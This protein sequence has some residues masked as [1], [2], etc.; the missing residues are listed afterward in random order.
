MTGAQN[1]TA[2]S[3]TKQHNC[4]L[5]NKNIIATTGTQNIVLM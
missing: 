4:N 3:R 2:T 5:R 1:I